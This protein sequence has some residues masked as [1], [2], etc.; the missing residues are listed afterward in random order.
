MDT[1]AFARDSLMDDRAEKSKAAA[2]TI[3]LS[4]PGTM[5]LCLDVAKE[6]Q[7]K[8]QL[9]ASCFDVYLLVMLAANM[10]AL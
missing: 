9:R 4:L 5:M 3:G 8:N 1:K 6:R 2:R 10:G 7:S